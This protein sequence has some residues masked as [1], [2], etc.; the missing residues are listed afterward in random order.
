MNTDFDIIRKLGEGTFGEAYKVRSR[1]DG[2]TYA[3]K[4]AKESYMGF[5][6]RENKLSEVYKA[7]KITSN[8]NMMTPEPKMTAEDMED[9]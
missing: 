8:L 4:K 1:I 2:R 5:K 3:V 7:L 6:D 9:E